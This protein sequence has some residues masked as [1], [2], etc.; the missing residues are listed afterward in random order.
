[1]K[2]I[3]DFLSQPWH[4]FPSGIAIA[5]VMLLLILLGK[6]FGVSSSFKAACS[7]L[8]AGKKLNTSI[9]TGKVMIGCLSLFLAQ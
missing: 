7:V 4:W 5:F 2:T 6:Q 9:M 3:V 8:G 1:M